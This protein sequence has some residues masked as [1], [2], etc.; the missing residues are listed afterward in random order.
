MLVPNVGFFVES[1]LFVALVVVP[2]LWAVIDVS[3]RPG[4]DIQ[5]LGLPR[6][7]WILIVLIVAPI[8]GI[9]YL[10]YAHYRLRSGQT[11]VA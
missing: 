4:T 7:A 2:T 5:R 9:G 10:I 8:G 3:K 6:A 1:A 11:A